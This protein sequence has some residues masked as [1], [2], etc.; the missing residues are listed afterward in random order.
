MLS[1]KNIPQEERPRERL[2]KF[3]ADSLSN[4]ELLSIVL[5]SGNKKYNLKEIVNNILASVQ[6]ISKLRKMDPVSLMGIDGV[7]KIKAIELSAVTELG[8]RIYQNVTLDNLMVC[9][10]PV[11][12]I[13]Y[14]SYL[15]RDK[16]QEEFYV[17][18][19]DNQKQY[20]S[21]KKLF[22]GT[23]STSIVH[24]REVFKEAYLLSASYIICL[25]NHPSG[26]VIPSKED[27]VITNK[28]K[29]IG[30]LHEIYLLDHIIIGGDNYYSFYENKMINYQD[31]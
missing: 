11:T 18:Y 30:L 28:I 17:L 4:E 13:S 10:D 6:D 21:H 12:I 29:D 14:F 22:V 15:F 2:Y 7:S 26:N 9:T 25:H 24:P 16:Q 19:L 20:L 3:G 1:L 8:K 5:K 27:I 23:I 31:G